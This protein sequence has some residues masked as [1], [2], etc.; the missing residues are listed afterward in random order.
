MI[1]LLMKNAIEYTNYGI[2]KFQ[3]FSNGNNQIGIKIKDNGNGFNEEKLIILNKI[4]KNLTFTN[5]DK[6]ILN[7]GTF[8]LRFLIQSFFNFYFNF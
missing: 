3:A 1:I 6:D 5:I 2:I 7:Y 4:Q 8:S